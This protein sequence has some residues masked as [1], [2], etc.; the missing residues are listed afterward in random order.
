MAIY[1]IYSNHFKIMPGYSE[2]SSGVVHISNEKAVTL[3]Q[4]FAQL[5][6]LANTSTNEPLH[7]DDPDILIGIWHVLYMNPLLIYWYASHA[8]KDSMNRAEQSKLVIYLEVT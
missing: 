1:L 5:L 7:W 3:S 6:T 4:N 2:V 8:N